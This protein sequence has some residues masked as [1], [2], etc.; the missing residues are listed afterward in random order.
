MAHYE[1]SSKAE[2]CSLQPYA[3]QIFGGIIGH[4]VGDA[5]GVPVEFSRRE[6]LQEQPVTEMRGFGAHRVPAGTWSDDTAMELALMRS[7]IDCGRFNY[8]NIMSNFVLWRDCCEFT[9]TDMTFD[10]GRTCSQAIDRFIGG[11]PPLLCGGTKPDNNGNG[12]LM[13]ILPVAYVCHAAG[14]TWHYRYQQVARVSALTHATE[15]A[16]LGCYIYTNFAC[17]LLDGDSPREAYAATKADHYGGIAK[18]TYGRY[19]RILEDDISAYGADE[20]ASSG[21]VVDSLEAALWSLLRTD[22]YRTAVET[23]VNLGGDTDSIGAITGS[24]A[25][26]YYG[27][28]AIPES[29]LHDLNRLSYLEWMCRSFAAASIEPDGEE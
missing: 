14:L 10:V 26:I 1:V 17:H 24:L 2:G 27:Y 20:I 18:K 16:Q 29:W 19:W 8:Y 4:A 13:R 15:L 9:A 28:D 5:L 11:V 25:G 12:S 23:A 22:S 21:Y 3:D 7:L 6:K